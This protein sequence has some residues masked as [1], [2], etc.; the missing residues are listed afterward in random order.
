MPDATLE[1]ATER[2]IIPPVT[3]VWHVMTDRFERWFRSTPWRE[4]TGKFR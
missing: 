4:M 3:H 2:R 1:L